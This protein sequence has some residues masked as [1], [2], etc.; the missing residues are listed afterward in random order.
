MLKAQRKNPKNDIYDS[1]NGK[2]DSSSRRIFPGFS[3]N[4]EGQYT[5]RIPRS[6]QN[7]NRGIHIHVY[8]Q[9]QTLLKG[10]HMCRTCTDCSTSEGN[11]VADTLRAV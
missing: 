7:R 8:A 3:A 6:Q 11:L 10:P 2:I 5:Q 1:R 4:D 9:N